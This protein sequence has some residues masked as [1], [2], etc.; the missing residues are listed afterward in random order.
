MKSDVNEASGIQ[1]HDAIGVENGLQ[2]VDDYVSGVILEQS[3]QG[4]LD[5]PLGA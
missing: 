4:L 1:Y 2:P 3:R 5:V